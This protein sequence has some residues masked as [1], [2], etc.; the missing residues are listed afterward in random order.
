MT[1]KS[2]TQ[3]QHAIAAEFERNGWSYDLVIGQTLVAAIER[4]G[5]LDAQ[6]LARMIPRDFL[7][8]ND[9]TRDAVAAALEHAIGGDA[10]E[11][12]APRPTTLIIND[13]RYSVTLGA[14]ARIESSDV[15]VG[16][17][18]VIVDVS[19]DRATILSAIETL[20]GVGIE[21]AWNSTAATEL[22]RVVQDR[23]D[24]T[25]DDVR[26]VTVEIVEAQQPAP[27][28]IRAFLGKVATEAVGGAL[29]AGIS[30]GLGAFL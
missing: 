1:A 24:V 15:N 25:A 8:R 30:A 28:R 13:N 2:P 7:I 14:G 16:G 10:V 11:R 3:V 23:D 17:T 21:G 5:E 20:V 19:S 29:G 22:A 27:A 6:V 18:Q 12:P 26:R 4:A 9:V